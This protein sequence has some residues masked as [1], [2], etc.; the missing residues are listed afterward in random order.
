MKVEEEPV[1]MKDVCTSVCLYI[2]IHLTVHSFASL[3]AQTLMVR[4]CKLFADDRTRA[5]IIYETVKCERL[6]LIYCFELFGFCGFHFIIILMR[7]NKLNSQHILQSTSNCREISKKKK[8][9]TDSSA[10]RQAGT[11]TDNVNE[12]KSEVNRLREG[13][14][15]ACICQ[16]ELVSMEKRH[17]A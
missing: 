4:L 11:S 7:G 12:R 6:H 15:K 3:A 16:I 2:L 13:S 14:K 17:T 8:R 5:S 9:K 10:G 1:V